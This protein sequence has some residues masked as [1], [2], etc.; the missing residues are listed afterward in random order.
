MEISLAWLT[1]CRIDEIKDILDLKDIILSW[2]SIT[3]DVLVSRSLKSMDRISS[4][5]ID[6]SLINE[7]EEIIDVHDIDLSW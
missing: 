1:K 3:I 2:H 4:N 6:R 7:I 5:I